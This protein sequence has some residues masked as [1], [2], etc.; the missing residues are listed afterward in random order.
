MPSQ[1]IQLPGGS[2]SLAAKAREAAESALFL[3][4]IS[5]PGAE[6]YGTRVLGEERNICVQIQALVW[7]WR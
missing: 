1:D 5:L 3:R 7:K 4:K 6:D 2:V